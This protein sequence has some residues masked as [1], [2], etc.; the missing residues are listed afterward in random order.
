MSDKMSDNG[1]FVKFEVPLSVEGVSR[2]EPS[3][4]LGG[5]A[6]PEIV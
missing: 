6:L 4:C 5:K 3:E 2:K 1:A